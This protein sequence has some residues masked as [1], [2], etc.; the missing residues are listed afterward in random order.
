MKKP[1]LSLFYSVYFIA[2]CCY[3]LLI[4]LGSAWPDVMRRIER[5]PMMVETIL[6]TIPLLFFYLG[7]IAF[8][9]PK[10]RKFLMHLWPGNK[11]L[12]FLVFILC[13]ATPVWLSHLVV[14][15][16][17]FTAMSYKSLLSAAYY[18]ADFWFFILPLLGYCS[19]LFFVPKH[20]LFVWKDIGHLK[21]KNLELEQHHDELLRVNRQLTSAREQ[22]VVE[23]NGL[24]SV[25]KTLLQEIDMLESKESELLEVWKSGRSVPVLL[26][27]YEKNYLTE[28][29]EFNHH[30]SV[31][32]VLLVHLYAGLCFVFLLNGSQLIIAKELA[33]RLLSNPWLVKISQEVFVNM[34][35]YKQEPV[36]LPSKNRNSMVQLNSPY[37]EQLLAIYT[38]DKVDSWLVLTRRL[39]DNFIGFWDT[40]RLQQMDESR[41][42]DRFDI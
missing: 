17:T 16:F 18:N 12:Q 25:N 41:L 4:N 38:A 32:H 2:V 24:V 20:A 34:L 23:L 22:L 10:L 35:F 13:A 8:V 19:Y 28:Q 40:D 27:Y 11:F 42:R 36:A 3:A 33:G 39:K 9:A 7:Y 30:F 26:G 14:L 6:I 29:V 21:R 37:R 15:Y 5:D 1:I 31:Y